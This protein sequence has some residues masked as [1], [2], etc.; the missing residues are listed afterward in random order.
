MGVIFL[1][2]QNITVLA[3]SLQ[4]LLSEVIYF[5]SDSS[6]VFDFDDVVVKLVFIFENFRLVPVDG[7][8]ETLLEALRVVVL[9]VAGEALHLEGVHEFLLV[10]VFS[11]VPHVGAEDG[12][13]H[14]AVDADGEEHDQSSEEHSGD[15]VGTFGGP[16]LFVSHIV[17]ADTK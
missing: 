8:L 13:E 3:N 5:V 11:P 16:E 7:E 17:V 2:L 15:R 12:N 4:A 6:P 14:A 9:G 10:L 1:I